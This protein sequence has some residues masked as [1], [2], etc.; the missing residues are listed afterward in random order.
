[1]SKKV[2]DDKLREE[3]KKLLIENGM[4]CAEI[5]R[6]KGIDYDT[7][8]WHVR[9]IE[10]EL[11]HG[12]ARDIIDRFEVEYGKIEQSFL[13][14][15][16]RL[17]EEREKAVTKNDYVSASNIDSK[18]HDV[19]KSLLSLIT[20]NDVILAIRKIK[21]KRLENDQTIN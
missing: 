2:V 11:E 16:K 18:I 12:S 8:Y 10:N 1:M 3:I 15:K 21:Q 5:A 17:M 13:A 14:T 9:K 19:D 20:D 6:Q 4:S 7:C